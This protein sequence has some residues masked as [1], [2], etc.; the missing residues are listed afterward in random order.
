MIHSQGPQSSEMRVRARKGA[1]KARRS[2]APWR[3]LVASVA[4]LLAVFCAVPAARAQQYD[5]NLYAGMR[6]RQIGPF[7][8]GRVTAVV[9]I[10]G[11]PAIYYIGTAGGG[12]WETEDAGL[13]WHPIFDQEHVA[14]IGAM[15]VAPSDSK[16]IYVGTGDVSDVG[17]AANQ[18]EG[19]YKTTDGGKTWRKIGL[20]HTRHIGDLWIDPQNPNVVLVAALG[21]TWARNSQRGVF[22]T[23]DGGKTWR[24]VLYKDDVTGAINLAFEPGN[25]QVGYAALWH[26]YVTVKNP[27][28]AIVGGNDGGFIYKTTD[29]GDTWTPAGTAGLPASDK[30]GRIGLAVAPG[31]ESVYAI[32]AAAKGGGL[33][34]SEDGGQAWKKICDDARI[35]GSNYFGRVYLDPNHPSVV[36]VMQTSMYRSANGGRTFIAFKGAP[37]GD[38]DHVLWIDPANSRWM[39]M[40]SDQGGTVSLDG[41]KSWSSWYNQPTG[42]IYHLSV[43]NRWPFWVYGTQQDSGSIGTLS[44]GDYGAITTL[45]WDPVAGYEFGYILPDPLDPNLLYAGGPGRSVVRIDRANRQV[46]TVS[47]NVSR[48]GDYR[49]AENPPLAF[50]PQNPHVLYEATQFVLETK[51]GGMTWRKI[52]P[53]LTRK[54]GAPKPKGQKTGPNRDAINTLAPSPVKAGVIWA[55]TTNGI[56]QLTHDGGKTWRDVTPPGLSKGDMVNIISA[57][58]FEA[59]TAYAAVDG[60]EVNDFQPHIYRTG[61]FGRTWKQVNAGIPAGS[62]V[63]VVREDPV[64]K[65]LLYAGTETGTYVS[66]D[67]GDRWQSLQL[68][69]PTVSVRDM[70]V[71]D[72]DLVAATYGRAFWILDDLTPLRQ[73]DARV[74]SSGA[75]LFRP[76]KAIRVR[77]DLNGDTPFPPEMPAGTNPPAGAVIDYYLKSAPQGNIALGIYTSSGKLVRQYS[78]APLEARHWPPPPEPSYWLAHPQPLPKRSGMNR[79]VW[80]LRYT[81]PKSLRHNYPISAVDHDTPANPRGPLVVPGKYEVRLTVDGRTYRQPL[82]VTLDPRVSA[83]QADLVKQL[84]LEQKIVKLMAT[85]YQGHAE[86]ASLR[87]QLEQRQKTLAGNARAK[88]ALAALKSLEEKAAKIEGSG[89]G[90]SFRRGHPKPSFGLLNGE[91]GGLEAVVDGA[92]MPPTEGMRTA[93]ADYCKDLNTVA[94]KWQSLAGQDLAAVN[95]KLARLQVTPVLAPAKGP[96]DPACGK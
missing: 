7:R 30:A 55:G 81:S 22:K 71:H 29:G 35:Q 20:I 73:I 75:W 38:D 8:A 40:G 68:N 84:A 94:G 65:G 88:S 13:T 24:R 91:L 83:T 92:D 5:P 46:R 52:S 95:A 28:E 18:G 53:E 67:N 23:T 57:S 17:Q 15:E 19:M 31:G 34:R 82:V 41:G 96:A 2:D 89:G 51:D 44:R 14:S 32:V 72:N 70:V 59:G 10:S 26:H 63:R 12:I 79:V 16:I 69:L 61:D 9:G 48:D 87:K 85:S 11:N 33:Y 80:A 25:P 3:P 21:R 45:D 39:I 50:S 78:S 49:L 76:E 56:I 37:G 27:F 1:P 74:A 47:V 42:Q 6:W 36:Y 77:R 58:P 54:A 60:F 93:Y 66:F 4:L 64:R 86:A 43:D 90:R 62:F